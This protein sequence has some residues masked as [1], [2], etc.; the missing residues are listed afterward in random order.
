MTQQPPSGGAMSWPMQQMQAELALANG[1]L[2]V[3]RD[4]YKEVEAERDALAAQAH[5]LNTAAGYILNARKPLAKRRAYAA[6]ADAVNKTTQQHL[7][8]VRAEAVSSLR[9]PVMLRRMWSGGEVQ[10]WLKSEAERIRR[11]EVE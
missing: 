10:D 6:L 8:E 1:Q 4:L 11:G 9:F 2:S 3:L 5:A 7:R